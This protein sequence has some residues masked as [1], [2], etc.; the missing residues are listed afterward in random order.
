MNE[1]DEMPV[2]P[3]ITP[4]RIIQKKFY[5][6]EEADIKTEDEFQDL[7]HQMFEYPDRDFYYFQKKEGGGNQLLI[8]KEVLGY[9]LIEETEYFYYEH[10]NY[11]GHYIKIKDTDGQYNWEWEKKVVDETPM[12]TRSKLCLTERSKR[13]LETLHK[14]YLEEEIKRRKK[15]KE[16]END[17]FISYASSES[18]KANKIYEAITAVGGRAFLAEKSLAPGED[19]AEKIRQAIISSREIWLLV[20]PSS[21][22][23]DWVLSEWGAGWILNKRI[24]PILYR[25]TPEQLP[26]RLRKLQ[27]IDFDEFPD[28]VAQTFPEKKN[29]LNGSTKQWKIT[30]KF[31]PE[32]VEKLIELDEMMSWAPHR[33]SKIGFIFPDPETGKEWL[34]YCQSYQV[35]DSDP[36]LKKRHI[37]LIHIDDMKVSRLEGVL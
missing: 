29:T 36:N 5:R 37:V 19:F 15:E 6:I 24:V 27:C 31:K 34:V 30:Q 2:F 25:C 21:L 23:S 28:L 1:K 12:F 18:K 10:P 14:I 3:D 22:K 17:I 11:K 33:D 13:E 16:N 8:A 9:I 32:D 20:S 7:I 26:D 4:D 35:D